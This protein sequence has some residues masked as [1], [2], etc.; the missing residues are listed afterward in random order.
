MQQISFNLDR[1]KLK[2]KSTAYEWQNRALEVIQTWKI[3]TKKHSSIFR[4]FK[5]NR[6]KAEAAF[7]Y[8][9]DR[10]NIKTPYKYFLWLITH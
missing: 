5:N 8:I 3:P 2:E 4:I 1:Y 10:G 7:R 9:Q 6:S